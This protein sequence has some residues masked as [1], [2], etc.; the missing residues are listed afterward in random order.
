[1][2]K[3]RHVFATALTLVG[4]WFLRPPAEEQARTDTAAGAR[5]DRKYHIR[6]AP[7]VYLPGR[8]LNPG[9]PELK[10]LRVVADAFEKLHPDTRIEFLDAPLGQREWLVTQL[11]AAQAPEVVN[12]NVEDVLQDVK[13]GW[14]LPL[15]EYLEQP[16]PYVEPGEPGSRQWWDMF[17]YQAITRGKAAPDGYSYCITLDMIETGLFYNKDIFRKAGVQPP[18]DWADFLRI[19]QRIKE[20]G[21]TPML[22]DVGSLADWGVDLTFDQL[23]REI[24]PTLDL[25]SD[26]KRDAYLSAYLDWDELSFLHQKGFFTRD[27]PRW[28]EVFRI[29]KDWR[30]YMP[31]DIA[32]TNSQREF[33]QGK[34]GMYW[35]S[36]FTVQRLVRDPE[37]TFDWGVF[38]LPPITRETSRFAIG[39]PQCVIGGAATQLE[40]TNSG[41]NDTGDPKTSEK[42]KRTI[43]FLQFLCVPENCDAVVNEIMALVPNIKGVDPHPELMP[44]HEFL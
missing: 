11:A 17:K 23:Y 12:V 25:R 30:R 6:V 21:Y 2:I 9:D 19:Q 42:L 28:R 14:Y 24:R 27:D 1:M 20:A 5:H 3:I 38:Y 13:K 37:R 22:A 18:R 43:A 31:K 26:P 40:V 39:V 32:S 34:A 36:S 7:G 35:S 10:Q 29:I 41:Y 15:D 33:V 16:N 4:L 8:R 44:F